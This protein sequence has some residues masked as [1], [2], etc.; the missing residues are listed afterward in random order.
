MSARAT[1]RVRRRP[2]AAAGGR[3]GSRLAVVR[4][5]VV[6]DRVVRKRV[7]SAGLGARTGRQT[8]LRQASGRRQAEGAVAQS[9]GPAKGQAAESQTQETGHQGRLPRL[10]S[11]WPVRLGFEIHCGISCIRATGTGAGTGKNYFGRVFE[12]II[13]NIG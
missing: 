8:P 5:P 6:P 9:Y 4:R 3:G 10:R 12:K 11:E 13:V 2:F 1:G 7:R